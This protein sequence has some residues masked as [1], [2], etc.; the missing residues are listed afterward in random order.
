MKHD[1]A[2]GRDA[3]AK[4]SKKMPQASGKE[5]GPVAAAPAT[6]TDAREALVRETAYFYYEARGRVG[7]HELEDWL[8][9]EAKFERGLTGE[10]GSLDA[11]SPRH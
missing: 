9:A 11:P 2:A 3:T 7:G 1:H 4:P 6:P 5:A 8:R 10:A